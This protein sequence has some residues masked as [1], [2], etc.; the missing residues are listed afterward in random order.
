MTRI[1][2]FGSLGACAE[3][4]AAATTARAT[5]HA[6]PRQRPGRGNDKP[7]AMRRHTGTLSTIC[8]TLLRLIPGRHRRFPCR[9]V[10]GPSGDG[11]ALAQKKR[12]PTAGSEPRWYW[13]Y[14]R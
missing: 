11:E 9:N 14:P 8:R 3:E 10:A 2:R 1:G 13:L 12:G 7:K 4:Q 6:G 5:K